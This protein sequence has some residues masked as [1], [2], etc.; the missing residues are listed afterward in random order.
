MSPARPSALSG[1]VPSAAVWA[2]PHQVEG[3]WDGEGLLAD[4]G[5]HVPGLAAN[6][7]GR[8]AGATGH[9]TY[10]IKPSGVAPKTS[11]GTCDTGGTATPG[12][13]T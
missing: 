4:G 11:D 7:T 2:G 5:R 12:K 9:G 3:L 1:P 10:T 6:S 13:A 8:Y